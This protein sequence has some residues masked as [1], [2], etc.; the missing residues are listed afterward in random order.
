MGDMNEPLTLRAQPSGNAWNGFFFG[1]TVVASCSA[2]E[3]HAHTCERPTEASAANRSQ[4]LTSS[5]CKSSTAPIPRGSLISR[6]S[7]R[8]PCPV[9]GN[10]TLSKF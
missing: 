10:Q 3:I 8:S 4:G 6:N 7:H 9:V 5:A 2:K 1:R